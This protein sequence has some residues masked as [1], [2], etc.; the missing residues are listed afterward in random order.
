MS[1][2]IL[3]PSILSPATL[4]PSSL[5]AATLRPSIPLVATLLTIFAVVEIG[6]LDF[7]QA[8]NSQ[9]IPLLA[10]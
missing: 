9:Y 6:E 4:A 3:T 7:S 10:F 8:S 1:A 5:T 2:T